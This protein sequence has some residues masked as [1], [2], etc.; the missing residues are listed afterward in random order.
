MSSHLQAN[1]ARASASQMGRPVPISYIV[2][3]NLRHNYQHKIFWSHKHHRDA[4]KFNSIA[5]KYNRPCFRRWLEFTG[6]RVPKGYTYA[7]LF[8]PPSISSSPLRVWT[9]VRDNEEVACFTNCIEAWLLCLAGNF[10]KP[11]YKWAVVYK[12]RTT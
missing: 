7:T 12:D 11:D 3:G 10:M 8:P 4:E 9:L 2:P 1:P 6:G 5:S